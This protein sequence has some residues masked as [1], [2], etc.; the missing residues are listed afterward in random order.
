[1]IDVIRLTRD[2]AEFLGIDDVSTMSKLHY[3]NGLSG[4]ICWSCEL[5]SSTIRFLLTDDNG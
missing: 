2:L 3:C 5:G 4:M 1:M